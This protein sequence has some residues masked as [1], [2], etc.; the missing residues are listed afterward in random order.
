M[1]GFS[2]WLQ[3]RLNVHGASLDEDGELGPLT[4]KA[5]LSFQRRKK[6]DLTEVAD[7]ATITALRTEPRTDT[8]V[9]V[10]VEFMPPWLAEM[11]RRMGL[12]E[13]RDNKT[14]SEWLR[15]GKFLGNPAKLP[16]C[17]DAVETCFA[18]T[19]PH[20]AL[21]SNPFW[22]QAWKDFGVSCSPRTGAVG[23]IKWSSRAGHV[24]LV[25]DHNRSQ[26]KMR[27]GNQSNMIKDA[28]FPLSKFIAFRWPA[29]YPLRNYPPITG[30]AS[31]GGSTR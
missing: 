23:V 24:G 28:W 6:L 17:G 9:P 18:R 21:P 5:I 19:L 26:V 7:D 14:L 22:A 15:A 8:E 2:L 16:W 20:E 27:G 1:D 12:H 30:D 25:I 4:R 31:H 3:K 29:S 10:A 13:V 11:T